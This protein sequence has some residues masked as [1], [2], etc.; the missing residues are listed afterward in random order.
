MVESSGGQ[1]AGHRNVIDFMF[2]HTITLR[3]PACTALG[4]TTL[5]T[6]QVSVLLRR[7]SYNVFYTFRPRQIHGFIGLTIGREGD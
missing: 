3:M 2:A 4:K 1:S 6:T 7:L 5:K